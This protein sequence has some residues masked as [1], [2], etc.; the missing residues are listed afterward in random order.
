MQKWLQR[1]LLG[2]A[3]TLL[4][5]SAVLPDEDAQLV[6]RSKSMRRSSRA[7]LPCIRQEHGLADTAAH[8]LA[9]VCGTLAD[10]VRLE[11]A[12]RVPVQAAA[13]RA[14][15]SAKAHLGRGPPALS[16]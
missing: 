15:A 13:L 14:S 16:L 3:L 10:P 4:A 5:C 1:V 7:Q 12:G 2:F 8:C 6:Q 9:A 11:F